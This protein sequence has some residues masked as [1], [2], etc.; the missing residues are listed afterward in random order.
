[1]A[2]SVERPD[3]PSLH[4]E[5]LLVTSTAAGDRDCP[6]GL[7]LL[8]FYASVH[9][10]APSSALQF[11]SFVTHRG[12]SL[13]YKDARTAFNA[14]RPQAPA[15]LASPSRKVPSAV[16]VQHEKRG[17]YRKTVAMPDEEPCA[18]CMDEKDDGSGFVELR[19]AGKHCYHRSCIEAWFAKSGQARCPTCKHFLWQGDV[20]SGSSAWTVGSASSSP[21]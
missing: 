11:H 15:S 16:E 6:S 7:E 3:A 21:I 17:W 5:G 1:M 4:D 14:S 12:Y 20:D 18:I 9:G 13:S 10:T 8:S 2:Y 19:C